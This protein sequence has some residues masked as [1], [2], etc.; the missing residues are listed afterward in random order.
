MKIA[1]KA[2]AALS[3]MSWTGAALADKYGIDEAMS[4]GPV[5]LS[6]MVWGALL[7][8]GIIW[9]WNKLF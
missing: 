8:A 9:V 4:D 6:D 7:V 5:N 1:A 2:A 3:W